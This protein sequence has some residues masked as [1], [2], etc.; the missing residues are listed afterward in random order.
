MSWF[1][2]LEVILCK[3][4]LVFLHAVAAFTGLQTGLALPIPATP[5]LRSVRTRLALTSV[6]SVLLLLSPATRE[7][8]GIQDVEY[9]E[10]CSPMAGRTLV[11][12]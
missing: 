6:E 9:G 4:T 11:K 1:K 10:R 12:N 8:V 3:L 2:G 7:L 5:V